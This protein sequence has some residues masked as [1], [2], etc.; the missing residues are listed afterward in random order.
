MLVPSFLY[1]R[2]GPYVV[3]SAF[4]GP[5]QVTDLVSDPFGSEI[6]FTT[7]WTDQGEPSVSASVEMFTTLGLSILQEKAE[8]HL[9]TLIDEP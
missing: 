7:I 9:W 3:I 6:Y 4:V 1:V 2:I 8:D 5:F